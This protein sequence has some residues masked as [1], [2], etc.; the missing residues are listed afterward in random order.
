MRFFLPKHIIILL[1]FCFSFISLSA[2]FNRNRTVRLSATLNESAPSITLNFQKFNDATTLRVFRKKKEEKSWGTVYANLSVTDSFYTDTDIKVGEAYEYVVVKEGGTAALGYIFSGINYTPDDLHGAIALVIDKTYETSLA[3]ELKQLEYDLIG[4]GWQAVRIVVDRTESVVDVRN[5]IKAVPN[6]KAVFLFGHVPVPYSGNIVPDGHTNNHFGAWPCDG[7]YGDTDG[8]WFDI[9]TSSTATNRDANKNV[10][11]DG[12]FDANRF[13]SDVDL[14]VGRV[15]LLNLAAFS[16]NDT[17]LLRYYLQKNHAYRFGMLTAP[18]IAIIDDNFQNFTIASSNWRNFAPQV[19]NENIVYNT[20]GGFDYRTELRKDWKLWSGGAGAGSYN[21]C[22]NVIRTTQFASDS[23]K[24]IFTSLAGS[25]FGDWDSPNNLLRAALA[26]KPGILCSF[27]GGIPNWV[28]H[29]MALG[30]NIG[31]GTKLTQN[32]NGTLYEGNFNSSQRSIHI[33]LMGDPTL[34]MHTALPVSNVSATEQ[35]T[36]RIEVKWTASTDND[37]VGYHIY[38]AKSM[39]GVWGRVTTD[40]VTGTSFVDADPFQGNNVYMVR[41]VKKET[42]PSGTYYNFSQ[43]VFDSLSVT[44]PAS[45][46]LAEK[47]LT[48]K[49]YPN[50][51]TSTLNIE[52]GA[53]ATDK[54][55]SEISN[56]LGQSI[57]TFNI[58]Q[59]KSTI[60]VS[61]LPTGIYFIKIKGDGYKGTTKFVKE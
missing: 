42:S 53:F 12:K 48:V 52:L 3:T 22:A 8:E 20:N 56:V 33:A 61:Q 44:F 29:H 40:I 13:N 1:L 18:R 17:E 49:A 46:N 55:Q 24:T 4:E 5:K 32:E 47:P 37:I 2:Q 28:L 54:L 34:R 27:W 10:P 45:I 21:S 30:E 39:H 60:N 6:V 15:D 50:P 43:G 16:D 23:I 51:A 58:T 59:Q 26:S 9:S 35:S 41:A 7:Y 31:Y 14:Q 36:K 25:Y 38:R 11:G 57:E 19:G